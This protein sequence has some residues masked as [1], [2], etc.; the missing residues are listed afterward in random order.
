MSEELPKFMPLSELELY[1]DPKLTWNVNLPEY[2]PKEEIGINVNKIKLLSHLAGL[3]HLR[4]DSRSGEESTE[5]VSP[6][7]INRHG[8]ATGSLTTTVTKARLTSSEVD[9]SKSKPR[10]SE[11]QWGNGRITIN[12]TELQKRTLDLSKR[13]NGPTLRQPDG[14]VK[15]LDKTLTGGISENANK[16]LL[17]NVTGLSKYWLG[18]ATF[19]TFY[20]TYHVDLSSIATNALEATIYAQSVETG[21]AYIFR[22]HLSVRERRL[23]LI[24]GYQ[25]DRLFVVNAITHTSR[26]V[27]VLK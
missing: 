17:G 9:N 1:S 12:T 15:L 3:A 22:P 24:P 23:S 21:L 4:I 6:T 7:S 19:F 27:K 2:I 16:Q 25:L 26:L 10:Y 14:W 8:A 20:P 18:V 13:E 5:M 11:Y